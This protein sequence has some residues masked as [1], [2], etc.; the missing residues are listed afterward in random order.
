MYTQN[1]SFGVG[2]A[3]ILKSDDLGRS[4]FFCDMRFVLCFTMANA[5]FILSFSECSDLLH[6]S[7]LFEPWDFSSFLFFRK[8]TL[9]K[10]CTVEQFTFRN[11]N[12]ITFSF[13]C[14]LLPKVPYA[15]SLVLLK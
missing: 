5:I 13:C 14:V 8:S 9:Q 7:L 10:H 3:A 4:L 2:E 1:H 6:K 11:A 15:K 12:F